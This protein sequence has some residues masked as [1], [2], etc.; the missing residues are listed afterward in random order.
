MTSIKRLIFSPTERMIFLRTPKKEDCLHLGRDAVFPGEYAR[1]SEKRS[2]PKLGFRV[3][4]FSETR[5][6][7]GVSLCDRT[8]A[9]RGGTHPPFPPA[10]A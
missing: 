5:T 10:L 6:H 8:G 2:S 1:V 3:A 4:L 9:M 7:P